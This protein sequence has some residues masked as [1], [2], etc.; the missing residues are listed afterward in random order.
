MKPDLPRQFLDSL[1]LSDTDIISFLEAY[2]QPTPTSI[3]INNSKAT[4]KNPLPAVPWCP[5]AFYLSERPR[6]TSDPAFHAGGYYPQEASSMFLSEIVRSIGMDKV[7]IIA[8]D[9]C[10]APGGKSTLLRSTLHLES[11]LFANEVV[12][13]RANLLEENLTKWGIPGFAITNSDPASFAALPSFFDFIA[14]DAPCSGEGL[15]RKNPKA[16]D[17]WSPEAVEFCAHR[18]KKILNDIWPA[19]K[20][21]G[22]M[23]YS[24][25]TF[26]RI[27]NEENL[28]WL[29]SQKDAE[30][31]RLS[32]IPAGVQESQDNETFGYRFFPH[33]INGEGF[34]VS[35]IRKAEGKSTRNP[36]KIK[37]IYQPLQYFHDSKLIA[38]KDDQENAF[39]IQKDHLELLQHAGSLLRMKC[40]GF[41]IGRS[42]RDRIKP[43]HGAALL[44][45][46]AEIEKPIPLDLDQSL[47]YLKREDVYMKQTTR[48]QVPVS[49]EGF[50]LGMAKSDGIRLVSQYPLNWRVR[51][52][53]P[54]GYQQLVQRR[55]ENIFTT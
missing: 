43:G 9:L 39:A 27:E 16:I 44:I 18:Q 33:L 51:Q 14:V 25:C 31:V 53:K 1:T 35:V 7:P 34:F 32:N 23:V 49:F 37:P 26:N 45:D 22:V 12:G 30:W 6:F 46:N 54:E 42:V 11:L 2:H 38:V 52:G 21:G 8:L 40:V 28:L 19:L 50:I 13:T 3:R 15:F 24:T 29:Q 10:A 55:H 4:L 48:G 20:P 17:E 5:D 41:P 36:K 47:A